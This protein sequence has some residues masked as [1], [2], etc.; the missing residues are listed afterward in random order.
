M[1][2]GDPPFE[3][4]HTCRPTDAA[5]LRFFEAQQENVKAFVCGQVWWGW[6]VSFAPL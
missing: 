6:Q 4:L 2:S 5:V 3:V 1:G